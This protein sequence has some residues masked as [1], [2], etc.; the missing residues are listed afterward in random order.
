[1]SEITEERIADKVAELK[2]AFADGLQASDVGV[3]LR[4]VLEFVHVAELPRA[5]KKTLA[6]RVLERVIDETDTP[7]LPDSFTDPLMKG[8]L[9]GV[10]DALFDALE[11]KLGLAPK[12][13]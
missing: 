7:W 8:I 4:A 11:G 1:M 10:L 12:Q 5:E 6:T 13:G 3:V 2:A 9:P